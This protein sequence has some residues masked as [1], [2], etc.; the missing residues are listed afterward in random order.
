MWRFLLISLLVG[1]LC[2][3]CSGDGASFGSSV[4]DLEETDID[5]DG[6]LTIDTRGGSRQHLLNFK[7]TGKHEFGRYLSEYVV[8]IK[9]N[10]ASCVRLKVRPAEEIGT[11]VRKDHFDNDDPGASSCGA[12]GGGGSE[13]RGAKLALMP[14]TPPRLKTHALPMDEAHRNYLDTI[15][16]D[17]S[18][19]GITSSPELCSISIFRMPSKR[20]SRGAGDTAGGEY[21]VSKTGRLLVV[22]AKK[23]VRIWVDEEYG[24]PC[25]AVGQAPDDFEA[26]DFAEKKGEVTDRLYMAHL[27]NLAAETEKTYTRLSKAYG[28]V[29]DVDSNGSIDLFLSP[30]MNR[31]HFNGFPSEE[32]DRF[33]ATLVN[34]PNDLAPFHP[35]QNS[36]SNEGEIIY[37]WVPDPAGIY[38]YGF[39]ASANSITS[40]YAKGYVAAQLMNL[41][42]LNHKTIVDDRLKREKRW[43]MDALALLAS[44][45]VAGNNFVFHQLVQY[46]TSRPQTINLF[47]KP[48]ST[49]QNIIDDEERQGMLTMFAWY[50]HTRLCGKTVEVCDKLKKLIDTELTGKPNIENTFGVTQEQLLLDFGITI[51]AHLADDPAAV[52]GLWDKKD[53]GTE[54]I[55]KPLEM[56][57][58]DD[59]RLSDT[60]VSP[61]DPPVTVELANDGQNFLSGDPNAP[62][63]VAWDRTHASPF[64][65]L[66]NVLYQVVLPDSDMDLK[67]V[68]NSITYVFI[69]GL[70][71]ERTDIIGS[72]GK[73]LQVVVMP[74]GERNPDLRKVHQE[75]TSELGH[76]DVRVVNLTDTIDP[77]KTYYNEPPYPADTMPEWTLHGDKEL[78][79]AGSID[80]ITINPMTV[81]D[82]DTYSIKIDPC[83]IRACDPS[84]EFYVMVQTKVR[85][86][87][88]QLVPFTLATS[89]DLNIFKGRN[90]WA[91]LEDLEIGEIEIEGEPVL[92]QSTSP[93]RCANGGVSGAYTFEGSHQK[94]GGYK[95]PIDN[96]L[97]ASRPFSD[98]QRFN[99]GVVGCKEA[100]GFRAF[101][102]DE[103]ARQFFNF[104]YNPR[105]E[106][107][108]F[109][110]YT[111]DKDANFSD[112]LETVDDD[113]MESLRKFI[114]LVSGAP[115]D[116]DEEDAL[117]ACDAIGLDREYDCKSKTSGALRTEAEAILAGKRYICNHDENGNC[118]DIYNKVSG[119][120]PKNNFI[121]LKKSGDTWTTYYDPVSAKGAHGACVGEPTGGSN[122]AEYPCPAL[123][124][125][126]R[127]DDIRYQLNVDADRV[128]P[129]G[130]ETMCEGVFGVDYDVCLDPVT[131]HSAS[132]GG[133]LLYSYVYDSPATTRIRQRCPFHLAH[134]RGQVIGK[135]NRLHY[136][137]F[138]VKKD[139]PTFINL[140]IGG[141]NNSQGRYL[142][143]TKL[144]K[145]N[146]TKCQ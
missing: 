40:N 123:D 43:L 77:N 72:F 45:Y 36:M 100:K 58:F 140:M 6:V 68:A 127:T 98:A 116:D 71:S 89:T 90:V 49:Y 146:K 33:S 18:R 67:L 83:A 69:T 76:M 24:N 105:A 99:N 122:T 66:D 37:L 118:S 121:N 139:A 42:V 144:F 101:C 131:I 115:F 26:L 64:P 17:S 112:E 108:A 91:K 5:P 27:R 52:R 81:G 11:P 48:A 38:T 14:D 109:E 61:S 94:S 102:P 34:R 1:Q 141:L 32:I 104:K 78:W 22:S 136:L 53:T 73:G 126:M 132:G 79:I 56:P 134:S 4:P 63:A 46:L 142:L 103:A 119:W 135:S 23:K 133:K 92:C 8:V 30:D 7:T 50:M 114:D 143:R 47:A 130:G 87:P 70:T 2:S 145:Y 55:T 12:A 25:R 31:A 62:S 124:A 129:A 137:W 107:H 3:T 51:A 82:A 75:K 15:P 97:F 86:F 88:S 9:S 13:E 120:L 138:K 80:N 60:E 41:I 93:G 35:Q 84:D 20:V 110:F 28:D 95:L 29:S 54:G 125:T 117:E 16:A 106:A 65:N 19:L 96:F 57:M 113:Y 10:A 74:L 128:L 21:T 111:A 85:D 59:N 44:S 39:L